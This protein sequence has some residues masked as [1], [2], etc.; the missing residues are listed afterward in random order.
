MNG[1]INRFIAF[2]ICCLPISY[3]III[4][5]VLSGNADEYFIFGWV[6]CAVNMIPVV[7]YILMKDWKN[8]KTKYKELSM[9]KQ[10][11]IR[12]S[13][14]DKKKEDENK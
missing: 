5:I 12:F 3:G 1:K 4:Y 8:N 13:L 11:F 10:Q 2:L 6:L 9:S 14:L 7:S